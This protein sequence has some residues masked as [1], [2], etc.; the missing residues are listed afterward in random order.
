MYAD[1]LE[2][3]CW[4]RFSVR[5]I[6]ITTDGAPNY[7][8]KITSVDYRQAEEELKDSIDTMINYIESK[9]GQ[10]SFARA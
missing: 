9:G 6:D 7:R 5:K 3:N 4:E 8:V 1:F 2:K 10:G